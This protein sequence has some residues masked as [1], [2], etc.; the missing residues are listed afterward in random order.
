MSK[1]EF[2]GYRKLIVE[3]VINHGPQ[4]MNISFSN[5][6]IG[7]FIPARDVKRLGLEKLSAGDTIFAKGKK[8]NE[9]ENFLGADLIE[10][11]KF[12]NT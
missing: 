7:F 12:Q 8:G 11:I 5:F 6:G 1:E 10:D 9:K 3:E 2:P 4:G